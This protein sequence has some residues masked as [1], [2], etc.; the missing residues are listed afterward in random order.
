MPRQAASIGI[1]RQRSDLT[2]ERDCGC[3]GGARLAA[4]AGFRRKGSD[5]A[6]GLGQRRHCCS[7]GGPPQCR[8]VM[9]TGR[10]SAPPLFISGCQRLNDT[11]WSARVPTLI[12]VGA[13]DDRTPAK[14]CEQ[15][16]AGARGRLGRSGDRRNIA[17][18]G[19]HSIATICM[20][21]HKSGKPVPAKDLSRLASGANAEARAD[22]LKRIP[23][24]FAR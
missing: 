10:I 1:K 4:A 5:R 3:S 19:M 15:M 6:A 12:L 7:V 23:E 24:W 20:S 22:A 18:L 14:I 17:V 21:R 9:M 13:L 8:T 2:G 16:V 11:A